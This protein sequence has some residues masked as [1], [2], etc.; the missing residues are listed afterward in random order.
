VAPF[1]RRSTANYW[2]YWRAPVAQGIEQLPSKQWV[3]GSNPSGR[4]MIIKGLGA[5]T[6]PGF[7]QK[8]RFA[9]PVQ[10]RV[11]E[12]RSDHLD[13]VAR[14]PGQIVQGGSGIGRTQ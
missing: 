11:T 12:K 13:C 7:G 2:K 4:A 10:I 3:G 1:G 9:N 5:I 14:S 8:T 6:P